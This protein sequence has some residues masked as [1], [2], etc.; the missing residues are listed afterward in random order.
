MDTD[1][2]PHFVMFDLDLHCLLMSVCLM[3]NMVSEYPEL[4]LL[5]ED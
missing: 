1:Q 5:C 4:T 3:V 2:A